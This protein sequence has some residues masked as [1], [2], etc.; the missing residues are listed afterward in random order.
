MDGNSC[1]LLIGPD[2]IGQKLSKVELVNKDEVNW[3]GGARDKEI[4]VL[5]PWRVAKE[6]IDLLPEEVFNYKSTFLDICFKNEVYLKAIEER[7]MTSKYMINT[8]G[9]ENPAVRLTYI[10]RKQLYAISQHKYC[11]L[12]CQTYFSSNKVKTAKVPNEH[13]FK[14]YEQ[15]KDVIIDRDKMVKWIGNIEVALKTCKTDNKDIEA[16]IRDVR[17]IGGQKDMKFTCVVGNPPYNMGGDLDFVNI[18]FEISDRYVCMITPAK[19]QTAEEDQRVDS[20]ISYGQF[21]NMFVK[22]MSYICFYPDCKDIFDIGQIDG[23]TYF[24]LDKYK[25]SNTC[26]VENK[27]KIQKYFNSIQERNICN[28]ESLNNI[29]NDIWQYIRSQSLYRP[30]RLQENPDGRYEIW[31]NTQMASG[32]RGGMTSCLL[33][34][35]GNSQFIGVSRFRDKYTDTKPESSTAKIVF[36]SNSEMEA[37]SFLSW[38][39]SKF[40]RFLLAINI[41]KLSNIMC[42]N[43]FR[44]VPEPISGKFDH[45]YTD[46][47]LYTQFNLTK[48]Y[49]DVIE[50]VVRSRKE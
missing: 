41:S 10:R 27:C 5:T 20:K 50:S 28:R 43:F 39:D 23:N 22:Y 36:A 37:R 42:N 35:N 7:L 24:L 29:G 25:N 34:V 48:Q 45:I 46:N 8:P 47:E 19:W 9:L 32:S 18:G 44:F 40:V 31:T 33:T 13:I 3:N 4:L 12:E 14:V 6:Q 38:M 16:F 30:F 26:I 11:T 49:I 17:E 15:E 2:N 21:R 1:S